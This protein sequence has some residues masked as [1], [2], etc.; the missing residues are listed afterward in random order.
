MVCIDGGE[1]RLLQDHVTWRNNI[2]QTQ[3]AILKL[4][5]SDW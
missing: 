4:H 5:R 1:G 2:V 3:A